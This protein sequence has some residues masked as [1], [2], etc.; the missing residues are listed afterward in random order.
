MYLP[1]F[2][3]VFVQIAKCIRNQLTNG[4]YLAG[5]SF[6]CSIGIPQSVSIIPKVSFKISLWRISLE[7]F[8]QSTLPFW[9][10]RSASSWYQWKLFTYINQSKYQWNGEIIPV[11]QIGKNHF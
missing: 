4:F 8:L 1:E 10:S 6:I 5:L 2:T 7:G 3:N 11:N 9:T